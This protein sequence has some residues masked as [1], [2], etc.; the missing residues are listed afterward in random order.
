MISTN[1]KFYQVNYEINVKVNIVNTIKRVSIV[2]VGTMGTGIAQVCAMHKYVTNNQ[3][4]VIEIHFMNPAP[5]IKGVEIIPGYHT[6]AEV[7]EIAKN[8]VKSLGKEPAVDYIRFIVNCI[9]E[10]M[11]NEA[12]RCVMDSNKP[13]EVD[14]AIGAI[15]LI[16]LVRLDALYNALCSLEKEFENALNQPRCTENSLMPDAWVEKS[17][18][19]YKY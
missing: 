8:F 10:V 5:L 6:A 4:K 19:V 17:E 12:I 13:E 3:Q 18:E 9:P 7:I 16:D 2:G 15:E 14:R 11:L 1:R